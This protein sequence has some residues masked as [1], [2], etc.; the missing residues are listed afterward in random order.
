MQLRCG[1]LVA[2]RD[3]QIRRIQTVMTKRP[4]RA[5][6]ATKAAAKKRSPARRTSPA[7]RRT[8]EEARLEIVEAARKHLL[9]DSFR[10]L[11]IDK[12]MRTTRI[13]RSAFY[14]YFKNVYQL[15]EVFIYEI[16]A[17]IDRGGEDWYAGGRE[18][19]TQICTGLRHAVEFWEKNGP[20]IRGLHEA[21]MQDRRLARI[22]R[23][24]V[25]T[26][27]VE[28]VAEK[29]RREQ[30]AGLIGPFNAREMS[31]ALN[32]FNLTYLNDR[33]GEGR[34]RDRDAVLQ[35]L[36]RVWI[37]TLYGKLPAAMVRAA[38]KPRSSA[39]LRHKPS[40]TTQRRTR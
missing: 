33:F 17:E 35:S 18:P 16:A 40:A 19:V 34:P 5:R 10:T 36:E 22:W 30:A 27:P 15:A 28:R 24:R 31:I 7:R 39:A 3:S 26:R 6:R 20:M 37:G 21:A 29:I 9:K 14:A 11:T 8:P 23:D 13:G 25:A 2:M 12:L 38:A 4:Q 1:G 32:R